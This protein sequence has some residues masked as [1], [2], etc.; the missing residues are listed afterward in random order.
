MVK[1]IYKFTNNIYHIQFLI[2][3]LE[4]PYRL[5]YRMPEKN[6]K[7]TEQIIKF[8]KN[9]IKGLSMPSWLVNPITT[10]NLLNK[11]IN[12]LSIK[13]AQIYKQTKSLDKV[14]DFL[15]G[16]NFGKPQI[17]IE[18]DEFNSKTKLRLTNI[19][20]P[21]INQIGLTEFNNIVKL[22]KIDEKA[23]TSELNNSEKIIKLFRF[24]VKKKS[25]AL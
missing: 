14:L 3:Q 7:K 2:T 13:L 5:I 11:F 25:F 20:K 18:W 17:Q 21:L 22:Y 1:F 4:D 15:D 24:L 16:V 12:E 8:I 9:N 10:M 6:I 19:F 23:K